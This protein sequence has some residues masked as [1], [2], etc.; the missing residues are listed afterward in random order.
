MDF[1]PG[2]KVRQVKEQLQEKEGIDIAQIRLV[3][4]GTQLYVAPNEDAPIHALYTNTLS[5]TQTHTH[6]RAHHARPVRSVDDKTLEESK[7]APGGT[8]HMVLS[9][10][11]GRF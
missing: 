10:R 7:V 4:S 9:L 3:F 1:E 11:G 6:A 5:H 2:T 8:I